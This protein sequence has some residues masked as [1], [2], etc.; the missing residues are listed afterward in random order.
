MDTQVT[1]GTA[2]GVDDAT[3]LKKVE[4]LLFLLRIK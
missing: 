3:T 4:I 2:T 1:T